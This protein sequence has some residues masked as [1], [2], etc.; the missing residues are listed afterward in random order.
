MLPA[1]LTSLRAKL[2]GVALL[3]LLVPLVGYR[4]V[5]E[6]ERYL[7]DGHREVLISA[8][9]L[10]SATLSDRPQLFVAPV[11]AP[12]AAIEVEDVERQRLVSLFGAAEP[13]V[14]ASLGGAYAPS[15]EI[16][17]ILAVVSGNASRMWVVDAQLRVRGL[18]GRLEGS[19][20]PETDSPLARASRVLSSGLGSWLD[21]A[22][23]RDNGRESPQS[24]AM[25]MDQVERALRGEPTQ[26]VRTGSEVAGPIVSVAQPIWVG[27]QIVGAVVLEETSASVQAVKRSALE[28]VLVVSGTILGV[29]L[30]AMLGFAWRITAR[31]R[32]LQRE[33]DAAIDAQGRIRGGIQQEIGGID[34]R[35]EIGALANTLSV[36]LER[37]K[38]Y[39]LHLEL[40][41]GRLSHELRTPLAVVRSSLD[42]LQQSGAVVS[43][44]SYLQRANDGVSRLSIL[45]ARLAESTQLERMLEN[46]EFEELDLLE[47]VSGCVRGYEQAYAPRIFDV[48]MIAP[49]PLVIRAVPDALVQ[50]LDKLVQNANDFAQTGTVIRVVVSAHPAYV[51]LRVENDGP[52]IRAELLES[53][54]DTMV[55]ERTDAQASEGHLGLGLFIARIVAEHHGGRI[56]AVNLIDQRGVA[57][58]V[59]LPR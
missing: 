6:M 7:R 31:V 35:D 28:S 53:L 29:A 32:R 34:R 24:R 23:G 27:E 3:L 58:V 10:L 57:I 45:I 8:A 25:V 56:R 40:L 36:T 59:T 51:E 42:N 46:A 16:Q 43:G 26:R 2:V 18:A 52:P 44:N 39:N 22:A 55:S 14:A 54:F 17:R 38:R 12:D 49:G 5:Q 33:A 1:A 20:P 4:F 19:A 15:E 47:L 11:Q 9:K 37:L 48:A 21:G 41:A 13:G 30:L 50:L